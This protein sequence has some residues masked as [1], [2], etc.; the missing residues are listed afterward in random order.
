MATARDVD[1][2][3]EWTFTDLQELVRRLG[4]RDYY[5]DKAARS[6]VPARERT[7]VVLA[8]VPMRGVG[9]IVRRIEV[10]LQDLHPAQR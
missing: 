5:V 6:G 7:V 3:E 8:A 10:S 9:D 1:S 4:G 2:G